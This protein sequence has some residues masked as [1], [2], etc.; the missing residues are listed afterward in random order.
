GVLAAVTFRALPR[1]P[2]TVLGSSPPGP[3][4]HFRAGSGQR[5]LGGQQPGP[6]QRGPGLLGAALARDQVV[7]GRRE[8]AQRAEVALAAG[9]E[10]RRE[11]PATR[12]ASVPPVQDRREAHEEGLKLRAAGRGPRRPGRVRPPPTPAARRGPWSP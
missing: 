9:G 10:V 1:A 8:P 11:P 4:D 6:L 2:P 7:A 3:A 12:P 5:G